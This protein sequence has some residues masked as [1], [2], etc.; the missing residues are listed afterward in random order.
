MTTFLAVCPLRSHYFQNPDTMDIRLGQMVPT[1]ELWFF[2][3]TR[4]AVTFGTPRG[5]RTSWEVLSHPTQRMQR[6]SAEASG[7][8]ASRLLL[9]GAISP[10]EA[11]GVVR[12]PPRIRAEGNKRVSFFDRRIGCANLFSFRPKEMRS[13]VYCSLPSRCAC[14]QGTSEKPHPDAARV[15]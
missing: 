9:A 13:L 5:C 15:A 12:A 10:Y 2:R 7:R 3:F 8:R 14:H 4:W 1:E 11:A 6:K